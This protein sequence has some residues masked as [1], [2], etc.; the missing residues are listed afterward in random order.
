M[1]MGERRDERLGD[2]RRRFSLLIRPEGVTE[3][4]VRR[5]DEL[6]RNKGRVYCQSCRNRDESSTQLYNLQSNA[7]SSMD[8]RCRER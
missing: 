1:V 2:W 3:G 4:S 5:R 6:E 7:H 8:L